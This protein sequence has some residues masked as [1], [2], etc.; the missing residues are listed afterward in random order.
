[1]HDLVT[2][3]DYE[4]ATGEG[5]LQVT[6]SDATGAPLDAT[7]DVPELGI[8][9][10]AD[11]PIGAGAVRPWSAEDPWL[12]EAT[13]STEAETATLR[14]GFRRVEVD[15]EIFRVNGERVVF[16]GVNRHEADPVVGR[17]QHP[18]NQDLDVALMKQ[19]NLNAVRTSH[20]P[21]HQRFLEVC[22]E[23]GL[24]VICEGD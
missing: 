20:Y 9:A 2:V 17:T 15:G 11:Q 23:A 16:R 6:V 4:P 24:Y 13:V 18:D 3:A 21:P 1:I 7:V 19:H 10:A 22:D 14:L 5:T 12:Y 8:T